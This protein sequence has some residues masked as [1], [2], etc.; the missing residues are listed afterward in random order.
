[1]IA[2]TVNVNLEDG[3][4]C[5]I[6]DFEN[7]LTSLQKLLAIIVSRLGCDSS[8]FSVNLLLANDCR[9]KRLNKMFRNEDV[10]T[11][12]LSFPQHSEF[13]TEEAIRID[14]LLG[15]IAMSYE[16]IMSE[17]LKFNINFFERCT[18]LFIH[19]VLHLFGMD[20]DNDVTRLEMEKIETEILNSIGLDDPF[21]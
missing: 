15:D 7:W 14:G 16:T 4:W 5:E 8:T 6:S 1:M 9:I 20:H 21:D 11:N 19:S 3:L 2:Q 12:V 13:S 10:P 17:S 18:H